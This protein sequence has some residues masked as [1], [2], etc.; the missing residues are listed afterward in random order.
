MGIFWGVAKISNNF[1]VCL[2]FL[3]FFFFWGGGGGL[4]VDAWS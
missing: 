1:G 3:M 4:T 2:I